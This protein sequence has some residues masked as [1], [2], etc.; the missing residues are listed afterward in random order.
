[1]LYIN[2]MYFYITTYL[3]FEI[4]T[5]CTLQIKFPLKTYTRRTQIRECNNS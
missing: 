2:V 1:M 3:Q 4:S 5:L